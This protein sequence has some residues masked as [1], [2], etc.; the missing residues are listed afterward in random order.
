MANVRRFL[1]AAA[2]AG[3]GISAASTAAF[4]AFPDRP[5][6]FILSHPP[7][8]SADVI[9]RLMQPKLE[10]L[11]G[12]PLI[13]ENRAGAGGIIAMDA[14]S[15]SKPDGYT[16]GMGASGSL[17]T[18]PALGETV[19]YDPL[20]SFA[21]IADT[22]TSDTPPNDL[23]GARVSQAFSILSIFASMSFGVVAIVKLP[24]YAPSARFEP[25]RTGCIPAQGG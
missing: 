5:I 21:P 10:K 24:L 15:K 13:I 19:P 20:K 4:S 2:V 14:L 17:A 25:G 6:R 18:S 23:S 22:N 7:G 1:L 8:G 3:V 9:A 12:Q 16:I 11:L